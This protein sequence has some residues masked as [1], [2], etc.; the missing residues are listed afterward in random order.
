MK[1]FIRFF[2]LL[3]WF[4]GSFAFSDEAV[5]RSNTNKVRKLLSLEKIYKKNTR[6]NRIK[7]QKAKN[8]RKDKK[9]VIVAVVGM[10][11]H[12]K[13]RSIAHKILRPEES[14]LELVPNEQSL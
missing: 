6:F 12:Y 11:V 14:N 10:G 5:A 13:D 1:F 2:I 9:T 8:L 3:C 7:L 4:T